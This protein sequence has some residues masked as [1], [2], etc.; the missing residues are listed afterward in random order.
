MTSVELRPPKSRLSLEEGMDVWIDMRHSLRHLTR[1]G[2]PVF[3]TDNAV[4][5]HEEESLTHL[6]HNLGREVGFEQ[7]V[8]F[9]TCK[10][11]LDY[12]LMFARRAASLGFPALTVLGGDPSVGPAR[13]V[14]HANELRQRIR[15]AVPE[16]VLGGWANPHR[17]PAEQVGFITRGDFEA[18]FILTQV[19]SHHSLPALEAFMAELARRAPDMPAAFG[20]FFYRSA[21]PRT[22]ERL[23]AFF[24]VP[25]AELTREFAGGATPIE[26]CARTLRALRRVGADKVYVSNLG[27]RRVH[28]KLGD[29]LAAVE[30]LDEDALP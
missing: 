5:A 26:V 22:L 20:V 28:Q 4:G 11:P 3:L 27:F 12:C 10:H 23:S 21:N 7:V 18:E 2:T 15:E 9:L 17:D 25:V 16:L 1:K 19:V 13:C 14:P 24:P 30:R 6:S 29:I 8:P